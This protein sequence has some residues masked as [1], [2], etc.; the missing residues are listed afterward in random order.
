MWEGYVGVQCVK[1]TLQKRILILVFSCKVL[2]V[3]FFVLNFRWTL[4]SSHRMIS[5]LMVYL[6]SEIHTMLLLILPFS[7]WQSHEFITQ[8][9]ESI[10]NSHRGSLLVECP[11]IRLI[12]EMPYACGTWLKYIMPC[13]SIKM[14]NAGRV[15]STVE[16]QSCYNVGLL[17]KT[18][19]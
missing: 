9:L 2:S 16:E 18:E 10:H 19:I 6:E 11:G 1:I 13:T 7:Y 4:I 8:N 17:Y 15:S 5:Y 3:L 12:M 14:R